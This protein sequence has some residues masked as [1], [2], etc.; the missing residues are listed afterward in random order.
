MR[1]SLRKLTGERQLERRKRARP[2]RCTNEDLVWPAS[3]S[4]FSSSS[5][6]P[7]SSATTATDSSRGDGRHGGGG[8]AG[9]VKPVDIPSRCVELDL[10]DQ[11]LTDA[12]ARS[13]AASLA[14]VEQPSKVQWLDLTR[15]AFGPDAGAC[16]GA[17]LP[18]NT[19]LTYLNLNSNSLGPSG[20]TALA[21]GL[22]TIPEAGVNVSGKTL[23]ARHCSRLE[24]LVLH[25]NAIGDV[26]AEALAEALGKEGAG[27]G[28]YLK[29]LMLTNNEIGDQ[30]ASALARALKLRQQH[31]DDEQ[32]EDVRGEE[33]GGGG[34]GLQV[35]D[36]NSN[37]VGDEGA[38]AI[39]EALAHTLSLEELY[40]SGQTTKK[41][42]RPLQT[43]LPN[44]H[45]GHVPR[46]SIMLAKKSSSTGV[47]SALTLSVASTTAS[48]SSLG[49]A[50]ALALANGLEANPRLSTLFLTGNNVG[51]VQLVGMV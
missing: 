24:V 48:S 14:S 21:K 38:M 46:K 1:E 17:A 7:S 30:G 19:A 44:A 9:V 37:R 41:V 51:Q 27:G 20:A 3:L 33:E 22:S 4:P 18:F 2:N 43:F 23:L 26:G 32:L 31:D 34:G 49:D 12:H 10:Y 36:L 47:D 29:R 25:N 35:L 45:S 28:R 15:N 50:G 40:L 16:L 8:D 6:S 39:G 5:S 42:A 13:L 11:S